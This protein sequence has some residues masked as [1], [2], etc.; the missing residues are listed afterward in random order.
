M[1]FSTTDSLHNWSELVSALGG[2]AVHRPRIIRQQQ[3]RTMSVQESVDVNIGDSALLTNTT[4]SLTIR[5]PAEGFPPPVISWSKDG[6]PLHI[7]DR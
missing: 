6:A 4:Q 1:S 2:A 5:C 3:K 7:T